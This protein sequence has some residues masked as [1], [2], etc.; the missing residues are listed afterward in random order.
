MLDGSLGSVLA[1]PPPPCADEVA[2][3]ATEAMEAHIDRRL[4]SVRSAA[5]L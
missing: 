2:L 3:I 1:G 4:R 5:A